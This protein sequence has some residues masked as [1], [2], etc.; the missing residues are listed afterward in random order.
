MN[1]SM[2]LCAVIPE[3][4][5]DEVR[6]RIRE[7]DEEDSKTPNKEPRVASN[8]TSNPPTSASMQSP[9]PEDSLD[10]YNQQRLEEG[11]GYIVSATKRD[12]TPRT[13]T[14]LKLHQE[15][16]EKALSDSSKNSAAVAVVKALDTVYYTED[17]YFKPR[18]GKD[19]DQLQ[20]FVKLRQLEML[21]NYGD[22]L[23]QELQELQKLQGLRAELKNAA[24]P[25]AN[26]V[27]EATL[28]LGPATAWVKIA[29]ELSSKDP[30]GIAV[31]VRV[32]CGVLGIEADHMSWLIQEWGVSCRD[33]HNSIREYI[34][35]C[36]W[37]SLKYQLCRD[38]K[39]L[40]MVTDAE[41][42]S[43]YQTVLLSIA[44]QYFEIDFYDN[45]NAWYSNAHS[46]DLLREKKRKI[47]LSQ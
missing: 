32:R 47:K 17:F 45:P 35:E 3:D 29:D 39:E 12:I 1:F 25:R 19:H 14:F 38:L 43:K 8:P 36:N 44:H 4:Y 7:R 28:A 40:L 16:Y 46:R 2:D 11:L 30:R 13:R 41:T 20:A 37:T 22:Y 27:K 26:D 33:F 42:A 34:T 6:Q 18:Q 23:N 9:E 24:K 10:A 31:D 5:E 15:A 21:A